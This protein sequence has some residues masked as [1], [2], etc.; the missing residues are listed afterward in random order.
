MSFVDFVIPRLFPFPPQTATLVSLLE[1]ETWV[2]VG[3]RVEG[4]ADD[5]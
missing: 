4:E 3:G 2:V 5:P 1:A